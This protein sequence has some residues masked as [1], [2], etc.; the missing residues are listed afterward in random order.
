MR[1]ERVDDLGDAG[2]RRILAELDDDRTPDNPDWRLGAGPIRLGGRSDLI[3]DDQRCESRF[4]DLDR[5]QNELALIRQ[6]SPR[7]QLARHDLK[8]RRDNL[9][10]RPRLQGLGH[11]LRLQLIRP[12]PL[13]GGEDFNTKRREERTLCEH[14]ETHSFSS[15]AYQLA[16]TDPVGNVGRRHRLQIKAL[17]NINCGYCSE[18]CYTPSL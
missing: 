17:E 15:D 8:A 7:R 4:I 2:R 18:R 1:L 14:C 3:A 9:H 13:T 12:T 16:M 5:G 10:R 11:R 6:P